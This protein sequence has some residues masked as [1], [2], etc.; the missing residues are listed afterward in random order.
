MLVKYPVLMRLTWF[1]R[2]MILGQDMSTAII[3]KIRESIQCI[4]SKRENAENIYVLVNMT[5]KYQASI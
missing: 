2:A 3:C 5:C 4:S 1:G